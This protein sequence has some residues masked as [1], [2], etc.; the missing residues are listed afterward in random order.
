MHVLLSRLRIPALAGV[1]ALAATLASAAA[2]PLRAQ[3]SGVVADA[4]TGAGIEGARLV[5]ID[6]N[7]RAV[8]T[9]TST[10]GGAF[11]LDV[12]PGNELRLVVTMAGYR[13]SE[14]LALPAPTEATDEA[15]ARPLR[16]ELTRLAEGEG[17]AP[18]P[19]EERDGR[20]LGRVS[21]PD[22]R[23][24]QGVLVSA[25]DDQTLTNEKG[26]FEVR[27]SEAGAI[28]VTFELLG[29]ATIVDTVQTQAEEGL[30]L[31]VAMPVEAIAL[32]PMTVTAVSRRRLLYLEDITRRVAMGFGDF[33]TANEFRD[34]GFPSF[35]QF[36]RGQPSVRI[37]GGVPVFRGATSISGGACAP[38]FYMDGVKLQRIV[39]PTLPTMDIE[40]VELYPSTASTPPEFIDSDSRCGVI[41]V[42]TKRGVDLPLDEILDWRLGG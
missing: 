13:A 29:R 30:F 41:A 25:D 8:A 19:A 40:L 10:V 4:A 9:S 32:E 26:F 5:V 34:R 36:L 42:W 2:G 1:L 12:E 15:A 6:R 38:T 22:G 24:L 23:A 33:A 14:P 18:L 17:Y 21:D 3:M 35:G 31:R 11:R 28:P 20:I 7:R 27:I 37:R 39:D 16:V